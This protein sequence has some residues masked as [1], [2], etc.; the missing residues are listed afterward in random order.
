[1][2]VKGKKALVLGLGKSGIA[3]AKLLKKFGAE[4]IVSEKRDLSQ[5]SHELVKEFEEQGIGIQ[6]GGH[7]EFL[8]SWAD[9]VVVSPGVPKEVYGS[10]CKNGTE[11]IGELELAWRLL[12]PK[13]PVIAITGTNGKTTTT[14]MVTDMLRCSGYRVFVGGNYGIPLSELVLRGVRV[15]RVVVEV[16]SFQLETTKHFK[17]HI[18]LLLNITPDHMERYSSL[19]EYAYYKFRLFETQDKEDY[20]VLYEEIPFFER[21]KGMIKGNLF[22]FGRDSINAR[23]LNEYEMLLNIGEEERYSLIEFKLSGDHNKFNLL[24]ASL[25]ARLA[26]ASKEAIREVVRGFRGFA[27]RMEFVTSI[28]GVFFVNDSKATNVD[29]TL[30]AL[31]SVPSPVILIM[32]GRHKGASYRIL[33]EAVRDK[34]KFLISMGEAGDV[35]REDLK[36]VVEVIRVRNL[37]EAVIT[38]INLASPGDTVLLSPGCS[39]FDEFKSYEERGDTFKRLIFKYALGILGEERLSGVLH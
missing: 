24:A 1:M 25:S 16:S 12:D 10:F 37:L 29:A 19:E 11:V 34:V 2:E 30:K 13:I 39:S 6:A 23:L 21:F 9:L 26:G 38:A 35:I 28:G 14:A 17:P 3:A 4:V 7:H 36:D 27:H 18:G 31:Q 33:E 5:I 15:D 32:G 8:R 20:A 22:R